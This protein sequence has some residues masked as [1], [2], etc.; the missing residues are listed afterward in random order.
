MCNVVRALPLLLG[1]DYLMSGTSQLHLTA[2]L[3]KVAVRFLN[4]GLA[5]A[6]LL[7]D[8]MIYKRRKVLAMAAFVEALISHGLA[9]GADAA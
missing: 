6:A 1:D 7:R 5:N 2:E 8:V 3:E 9:I 4:L